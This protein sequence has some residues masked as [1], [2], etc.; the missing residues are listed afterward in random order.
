MTAV[1]PEPHSPFTLCAKDVIAI[2]DSAGIRQ[3][4][5]LSTAYTHGSLR[6]R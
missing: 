2:L 5:V 4:L 1:G 3:A 6:G